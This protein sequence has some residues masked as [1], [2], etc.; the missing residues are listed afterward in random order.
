MVLRRKIAT[1]TLSIPESV[2]EVK[3]LR[4]L[5]ISALN[6]GLALFCLGVNEAL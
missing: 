3:K 6:R 2:Y 1:G 5:S 4:V